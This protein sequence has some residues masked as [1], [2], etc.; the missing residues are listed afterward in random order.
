MQTPGRTKKKTSDLFLGHLDSHNLLVRHGDLEAFF[1]QDLHLH[2]FLDLFGG[3][4][5]ESARVKGRAGNVWR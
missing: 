4:C 5:D 1:D 3:Y 2:Q